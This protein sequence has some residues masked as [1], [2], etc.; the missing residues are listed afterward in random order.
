MP[1]RMGSCHV[2]SQVQS[3][4]L[5]GLSRQKVTE[6]TYLLLQC[7]IG[8]IVANDAILGRLFIGTLKGLAFE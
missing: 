1:G 6:P 7:Q 4:D 8:N 5:T 2:P 3:S